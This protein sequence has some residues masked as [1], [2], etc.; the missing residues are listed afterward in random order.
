LDNVAEKKELEKD[1]P[2]LKV[3]L[4][5]LDQI[6]YFDRDQTNPNTGYL[7]DSVDIETDK[8]R[9]NKHVFDEDNEDDCDF[10]LSNSKA[11]NKIIED[12]DDSL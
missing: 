3:E 4:G 11:G 6:E 7:D 12:D 5:N 1:N 10:D 2:S 8:H 9:G